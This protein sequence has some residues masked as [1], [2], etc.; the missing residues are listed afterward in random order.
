V[1][2][3][4]VLDGDHGLVGKGGDELDLIFRKWPRSRSSDRYYADG[5]TVSNKRNTESRSVIADSLGL[6]PS[7]VRVGHHVRNM[8]HLAFHRRSPCSGPS[9]QQNRMFVIIVLKF[10]R[11]VIPSRYTINFLIP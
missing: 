9:V 8:H 7:E 5:T 3:S 2:Q 10:L 11:H 4:H 1:E 6:V